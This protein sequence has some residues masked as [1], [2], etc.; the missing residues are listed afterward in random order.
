[1]HV[2]T[3]TRKNW[4]SC[5]DVAP[6]YDVISFEYFALHPTECYYNNAIFN[7]SLREQ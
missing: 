5:R 2:H 4:E 3:N 7:P 6:S 1:M